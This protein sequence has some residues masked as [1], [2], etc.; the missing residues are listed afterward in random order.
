MNLETIIEIY[1][2]TE[3]FVMSGYD[4]AII[5]VD[6]KSMVLIYS[7][8]KIIEILTEEMSEESAMDHFSYNIAG[9]CNK[10]SF[11]ILCFDRY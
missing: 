8:K 4:E 9:S 7:V 3:F 2:E 11:L 10:D 1:P 5:G 6:E